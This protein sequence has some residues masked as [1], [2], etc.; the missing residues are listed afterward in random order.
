MGLRSG[1]QFSRVRCTN[2]D[3]LAGASEFPHRAGLRTIR[4]RL[5]EEG[6]RIDVEAHWILFVDVG[7]RFVS[8]TTTYNAS[9]GVSM[10]TPPKVKVAASF[11]LWDNRAG[12]L[13]TY[14]RVRRAVTHRGGF[15]G[16]R[17]ASA[18]EEVGV[19]LTR[20]TQRLVRALP[21]SL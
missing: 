6:T 9:T 21:P 7:V 1:S 15:F 10:T 18:E 20:A 14:R 16:S 19:A 2:L 8:G 11:S 4:L 3:L 5:P 13:V 12:A 17:H